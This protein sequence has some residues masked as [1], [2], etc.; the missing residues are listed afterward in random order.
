MWT[1]ETLIHIGYILLNSPY[2][3]IVF[4][5][6]I[7]GKILSTSKK[8]RENHFSIWRTEED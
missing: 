6:E 5:V 1:M 8:Y 2:N 3:Q 4:K 7:F